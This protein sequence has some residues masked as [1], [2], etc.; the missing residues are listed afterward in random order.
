LTEFGILVFVTR[1]DAGRAHRMGQQRP[2]RVSSGDQG[3]GRG[4]RH[5]LASAK[6]RAHRGFVCWQKFGK[7]LSVEELTA[8][9]RG[10]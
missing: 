9:L 1:R 8:L 7:L 3:F 2:H 6:T 10:S 5:E 4:A